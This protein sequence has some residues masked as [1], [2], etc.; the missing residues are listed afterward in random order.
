MAI[1]FLNDIFHE[2]RN[3]SLHFGE[4]IQTIGW[5]NTNCRRWFNWSHNIK[6]DDSMFV[7]IKKPICRL[8]PHYSMPN[9]SSGN[10]Y[11]VADIKY[12]IYVH[13]DPK[14][15]LHHMFSFPPDWRNR[16][17]YYCQISGTLYEPPI[18]GDYT[19]TLGLCDITKFI[20]FKPPWGQRWHSSLGNPKY[21]HIADFGFEYDTS[22]KQE[23]A[24]REYYQKHPDHQDK[25]V[26]F[27][28]DQMDVYL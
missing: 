15:L 14:I 19:Y 22:E 11:N 6:K 23:Q 2:Y 26:L 20:V 25:K 12:S 10:S 13:A 27:V 1:K 9:P 8:F 28:F 17:N 5:L 21:D 18:F 7:N 3:Q 24:K 4:K 16:N